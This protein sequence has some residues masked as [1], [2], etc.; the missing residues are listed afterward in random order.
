MPNTGKT[1]VLGKQA[2]AAGRTA[3][4][5]QKRS[6]QDDNSKAQPAIAPG[7]GLGLHLLTKEFRTMPMFEMAMRIGKPL[8]KEHP[9]FI[10]MIDTEA[11]Q[12]QAI[13]DLWEIIKA[14]PKYRELKEPNW[15]V[16][17]P[18]VHVI[19]W[20]LRKIGP[21]AGGNP[22]TIDTYQEGRKL[23]Y[24]FVVY[25]QYSGNEFKHRDEFIPLDFLPGLRHRDQLLHDLI[26]DIIALVHRC[27]KVPLWD[28]DGDFSEAMAEMQRFP[29][30]ENT[31]IG[32]RMLV[33]QGIAAEYL[34]LV[35]QRSRVVSVLDIE[36]Q[37]ALYDAKSERKQFMIFWIRRGLNVAATGKKIVKNTFIPNYNDGSPG[38]PFRS[39][40]FVW[41]LH[42][43]DFV[44]K[45]ATS[46]ITED[47]R[48]DGSYPPVMFSITYPGKVVKLPVWDDYPVLLYDFMS[49]GF[50]KIL[51]T[52]RQYYYRDFFERPLVSNATLMDTL[53]DLPELQISI[54]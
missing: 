5:G 40:K 18:P 38:T 17:T 2:P 45:A 37:I 44:A 33:Y 15:S 28:S 26:V 48:A 51:H 30:T 32:R 27:N 34:K 43:E 9:G 14:Q 36:R 24:R 23:R 41:C 21:L 22:W 42:N 7:I 25:K 6:R 3:G 10:R 13:A 46:K 47:E 12:L 8:S 52:Y 11:K 31:V 20:L 49:D 50:K 54:R 1:A 39:Y 53:I 16:D 4:R 35:K 29:A 19:S